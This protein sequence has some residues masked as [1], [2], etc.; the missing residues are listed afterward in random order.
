MLVFYDPSKSVAEQL[1]DPRFA[2]LLN[3]PARVDP[4]QFNLP[5][6]LAAPLEEAM[7]LLQAGDEAEISK[8]IVWKDLYILLRSKLILADINE[9]SFGGRPSELL[10]AYLWKIPRLVISHRYQ[11]S[12]WAIAWTD[13]ILSENLDNILTQLSYK[14][15][16]GNENNTQ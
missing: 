5:K 8:A 16:E 10:F 1:Q 13:T 11:N 14:L 4:T 3:Q 2:N 9:P 7:P 12:P 15:S 6:L